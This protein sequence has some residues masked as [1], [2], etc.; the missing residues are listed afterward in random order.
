M[1]FICY[2]IIIITHYCEQFGGY[3]KKSILVSFII[4]VLLMGIAGCSSS[5]KEIQNIVHQSANKE[6]TFYGEY[7]TLPTPDIFTIGESERGNHSYSYELSNDEKDSRVGLSA[8]L[9]RLTTEGFICEN[10]N[11][12]NTEIKKGEK[13]IAD[14]SFF[15]DENSQKYIL[16][17]SIDK[18]AAKPEGTFLEE[19]DLPTPDSGLLSGTVEFI[20]RSENGGYWYDFGTN[21]IHLTLYRAALYSKGYTFEKIEGTN[22]TIYGIF[23]NNGAEMVA[24]FGGG[25]QK[26]SGHILCEITF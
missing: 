25:Q 11:D 15:Q 14:V 7:P 21:D 24:L 19:K 26:D 18:M 2:N 5:T 23:K 10:N 6:I 13:K 17:V 16:K 3:M 8:Y 12:T 4:A 9:S 22:P 20:E 1:N